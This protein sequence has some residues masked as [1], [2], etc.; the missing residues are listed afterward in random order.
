M[1]D[2][3]RWIE[4]ERRVS[5]MEEW[6]REMRENHLPHIEGELEWIRRHLHRPSWLVSIFITAVTSLAVGL[7]VKL[8]GG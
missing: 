1:E 2:E 4:M 3:D 5:T 7:A 6:I 8:S